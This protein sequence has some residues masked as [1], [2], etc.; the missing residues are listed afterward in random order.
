M[1]TNDEIDLLLVFLEELTDYQSNAGCNDF[2]FPKDWSEERKLAI[3]E[4]FWEC[5]REEQDDPDYEG[6]SDIE[7]THW[8]MYKLGKLKT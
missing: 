4:P 7:L 1:M 8:L 6:Y 2:W 5:Q 3:L